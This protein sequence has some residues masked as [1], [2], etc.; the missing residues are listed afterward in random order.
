MNQSW[1]DEVLAELAKRGKSIPWLAQQIGIARSSA[2][3]LFAKKRDGSMVQTGCSEVPQICEL[4]GVRPPTVESPPQL[5]PRDARIAELLRVAPDSIK[6][7]VIEI[8]STRVKST[9]DA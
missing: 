5:Q 8:L 1:K 7:A 9:D 2:Y 6:D 3:K 4:L